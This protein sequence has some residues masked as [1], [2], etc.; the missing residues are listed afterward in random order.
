MTATLSIQQSDSLFNKKFNQVTSD[1]KGY[2]INQLKN[3]EQP[4]SA[5]VTEYLYCK[6]REASLK[7]ASR[8]NTIDR[9]YRLS[10]FLKNKS[11]REMTTEDIFSF[12]DTLRRTE[13]QDPMHKWIGTYNLSLVKII[14]FFK[15]LYEPGTL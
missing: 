15:W 8:A 2:R 13:T 4:N 3:M 12:L 7:P 11:F 1:L 14:S 5:L 6:M 10:L 9:L